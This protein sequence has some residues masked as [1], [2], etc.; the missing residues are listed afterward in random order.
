MSDAEELA[1]TVSFCLND[2]VLDEEL[3]LVEVHLGELLKQAVFLGE[4]HE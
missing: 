1:V 4:V 3:N 2:N